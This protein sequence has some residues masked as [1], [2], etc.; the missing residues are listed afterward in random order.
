M[1]TRSSATGRRS[2]KCRQP[3]PRRRC[4]SCGRAGGKRT[5]WRAWRA[6][7]QRR[8]P[9]PPAG[10]GIG[11]VHQHDRLSSSP[12]GPAAGK[13]AQLLVAAQADRTRRESSGCS[14]GLTAATDPRSLTYDVDAAKAVG[15]VPGR[16]AR[17]REVQPEREGDRLR[18][19]RGGTGRAGVRRPRRSS[20]QAW[21]MRVAALRSLVHGDAVE[22]GRRPPGVVKL[23][24]VRGP[25]AGRDGNHTVGAPRGF[26]AP[27]FLRRLRR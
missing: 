14:V 20:C 3:R 23:P 17:L 2:G 8:V 11:P 1:Q 27:P 5:R 26:P 22:R 15:H 9:P 21:E 12:P 13:P 6:R 19:S 7:R 24:S 4:R 10:P 18:L 16:P 25:A